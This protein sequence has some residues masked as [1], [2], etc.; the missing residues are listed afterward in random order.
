MS[1]SAKGVFA[2]L[3]RVTRG[4]PTVLKGDP[5]GNNFLYTN[6]NSVFIR[7]IENPAVCD[8]YTQH[9]KEVRV[10]C[11]A[12][13][14]FYIASGD[15]SGKVRIWDTTQKEHLL[16]YEYQSLGGQIND[17]AWSPDSKRIVVAG[18]G[19]EKF[20]NVFLWDSGS[21]VGDISNHAKKINSVDYKQTRPYRICTA[22]ED[23][24]VGFFEGPPFKYSH[25]SMEHTNFVN[26]VRFAPDGSYY[27]SGGSDGKCFMFDGKTGELKSQLGGEGAHK[28]SVFGVSWSPDSKFVLTASADKTAKL[29]DVEKNSVV[30][31]F[32]I[33]DEL[34]DQQ[35]GCLWQDDYMLSL[36]LSGH[37]NY[38]DK[39][40]P[41]TPIRVI[42]GH[43]RNITALSLSEDKS[44]LYTGS[45]DS[46]ICSWDI[47]TGQADRFKGNDGHKNQVTDMKVNE[48]Q[49]VTCGMDDTVRF[50]SLETQEY[51]P[52]FVGMDSQPK[53]VAVGKNGLAIVPCTNEIV[54]IQN[55]KKVSSL[56]ANYEPAS[57]AVHPGQ[58][59]VA[60]GGGND[61]RIHIFN[62]ENDTLVEKKI[63]KV[64]GTVCDLAYSPDGAFLASADSGRRVFVFET[65][66][67]EAAKHE[68]SSHTARINCLAWTTD[69]KHVAS[70]GLSTNININTVG[71][72]FGVLEM[73]ACHPQSN[74]TRLLWKDDNNLV[75]VGHDCCVRSWEIS[76]K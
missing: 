22:S 67:Y 35:L 63:A 31:E 65:S 7:D 58:T 23:K 6:G 37:I 69:S 43:S 12:P 49:L 27:V 62:L 32:K 50:T 70:G 34:D 14:G 76:H 64:R 60:V 46:R 9:A 51:G 5:K 30:T 38:L 42:K 68:W 59:E 57:A 4:A 8:V 54:V 61:E 44:T 15:V 45:F 19:R 39:N 36:S 74:I 41:S 10:A 25:M 1:F 53:S 24:A 72:K 48:N 33:G 11:Y 47:K 66:N 75:S 29:W 20:A 21:K 71:D 56:K 55:G 13:S 17:I 2:S 73:K 18:E 16:K 3:P 26:V 52:D 40:N 28:G